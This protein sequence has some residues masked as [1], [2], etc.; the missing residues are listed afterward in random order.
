MGPPKYRLRW[1]YDYS[2][3]PSKFGMWG[4][5]GPQN[6]MATKAWCHNKEGLTRACIEGKDVYT[7]R[8][9]TLAECEGWDFVNFEWMVNASLPAMLAP[10][11][12][13][14]KPRSRIVGLTL[15]TRDWRVDIVDTG[16]VERRPR[17]AAEKRMNL[18]TFGR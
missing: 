1:R 4:H 9:V 11:F 15:V 3:R 8:I 7:Q 14:V 18:A 5:S 2:G 10:G 13:S 17:T 16:E 6:D 12:G